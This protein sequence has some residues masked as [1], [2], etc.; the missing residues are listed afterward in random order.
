[1]TVP[2][3]PGNVKPPTTTPATRQQAPAPRTPRRRKLLLAGGAALI[4]GV[5][6][7]ARYASAPVD[8]SAAA[9]E[10]D[11]LER[12]ADVAPDSQPA[13]DKQ[14]LDALP[15]SSAGIVAAPVVTEP[16]AAPVVKP[17]PK[18]VATMRPAKPRV[19]A[20]AKSAAPIAAPSV[21]STPVRENATATSERAPFV[22]TQV[23]GT[24]PVTLTGCLEM[25]V[26]RAEF[27]LS[28]TDG[29]DVPKT[30]SW[31]TAFLTKRST[32]VALV[33]APDYH[34]LQ[35]QV[36]KRIAATGQLTDREMKVS[37]IRVV[38]SSCD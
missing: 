32:P 35:I 30:R 12:A 13:P 29:V 37:S 19:A 24:P 22:S 18:K 3:S 7:I 21:A 11:R 4:L 2:A 5:L 15:V 14:A 26:D 8:E 16:P 36:G 20:S 10:P 17:R 25:S 23:A 1:M 34:A 33:E 9:D 31:R 6:A 38:G 28:D 27:R